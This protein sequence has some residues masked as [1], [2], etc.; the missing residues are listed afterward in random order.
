MESTPKI[1]AFSGSTR[2]ASFNKRLISLAV[3]EADHLGADVTLVNLGDFP[4]PIY[5]GDIEEEQGVPKNATALRDIMIAHHGFIIA[6]PEYNSAISPLLKNVLDWTSRP[7]KTQEG[8][9]PFSG[10]SVSLMSASPGAFGGF[11]GLS[12]LS[13]ILFSLGMHVLP[14]MVIVPSAPQAFSPEGKLTSER[15]QHS[16][17]NAVAKHVL[18]LSVCKSPTALV[19]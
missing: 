14:D 3:A 6:S 12:S 15:L 2:K 11:R 13:S 8:K 1:L 17:A 5:D 9:L 19:A 7:T 16:L 18:F 10:K 4:L